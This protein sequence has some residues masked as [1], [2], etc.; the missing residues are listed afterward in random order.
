MAIGVEETQHARSEKKD[1]T[2]KLVHHHNIQF[3][4]DMTDQFG[5][6]MQQKTDPSGFLINKFQRISVLNQRPPL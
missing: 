1:K 2:K 6:M 4:T 5:Y 3:Q